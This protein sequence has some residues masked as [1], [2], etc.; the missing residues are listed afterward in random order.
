MVDWT[1]KKYLTS[2]EP[3]G[4]PD[5]MSD[6]LVGLVDEFRGLLGSPFY[7]TFGTQGQH[8]AQW[9]AQ[10]LAVDGV[11]DLFG[12][13]PIDVV[14]T[15]MRLPFHGIGV[16]PKA[17]HPRC[18]KPL[19]LHFDLRGRDNLNGHAAKRWLAVPDEKS[20]IQQYSLDEASL[21]DFGL[22]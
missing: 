1:T 5:L 17:R 2:S 14:F 16:Y 22:L 7:V 10:G 15:A 12:K 3:W 6:D 19:G 18:R 4:D 11:V 21:R 8:V 20:L 13:S 9:H